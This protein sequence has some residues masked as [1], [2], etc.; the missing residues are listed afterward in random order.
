MLQGQSLWVARSSDNK[1]KINMTDNT[2]K[3]NA[4]PLIQSNGYRVLEFNETI[5]VGDEI[6]QEDAQTWVERPN[7]VGS[8]ADGFNAVRRP[9]EHNVKSE[10]PSD[11]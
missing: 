7:C 11:G 8:I 5:Q 3:S 9:I 6:L 4:S 2:E 1:R 10:E